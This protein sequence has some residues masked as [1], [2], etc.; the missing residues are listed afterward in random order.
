MLETLKKY[1]HRK[2]SGGGVNCGFCKYVPLTL[3]DIAHYIVED[4]FVV[5]KGEHYNCHDHTSGVV[6]VAKTE[7]GRA[8][9]S[10]LMGNV[11]IENLARSIV[12]VE[13]K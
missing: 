6:V 7:V 3:E 5:K 10:M 1:H 12:R 9:L 11:T 8:A 13:E 4:H 2:C